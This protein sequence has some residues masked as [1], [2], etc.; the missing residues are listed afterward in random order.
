MFDF[1]FAENGLTAYRKQVPLPAQS[2]INHIGEERYQELVNFILRYVA[3][4]K[5][6]KKRCGYRSLLPMVCSTAS[7]VALLSSTAGA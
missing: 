2:F 5:I 7:A 4:L 1:A 6:P 3:D